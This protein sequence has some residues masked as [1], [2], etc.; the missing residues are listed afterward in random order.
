MKAVLRN[1]W[2]APDGVL[3]LKDEGGTELPDSFNGVA[4]E[5]WLPSTAKVVEDDYKPPRKEAKQAA[6][7]TLSQI[8][9]ASTSGPLDKK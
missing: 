7:A 8:A 1:N 6:P 4:T 9:K 5:K 3:Y 2:F